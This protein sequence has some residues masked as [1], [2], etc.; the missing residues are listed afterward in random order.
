[1]KKLTLALLA[2]MAFSAEATQLTQ[3]SQVAEGVKQGKEM[4]FVLTVKDC[5]TDF[6]SSDITTSLK[7]DAFM[8]IGDDRVTASQRHFTLDD[9][10]MGGEPA[11]GYG[12]YMIYKDGT[13]T[14]KITLMRAADYSKVKDYQIRCELGHGFNVFY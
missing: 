5:E 4:S 10:S 1:M 3:F 8:L 7:P 12:K 13:V 6:P 11:F 14:V 2:S 9:P